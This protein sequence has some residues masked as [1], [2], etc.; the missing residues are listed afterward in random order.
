MGGTEPTSSAV[1]GG[2][3]VIPAWTYASYTSSSDRLEM[4]FMFI[5]KILASG[6]RSI[7]ERGDIRRDD[8][9]RF[10][11]YQRSSLVDSGA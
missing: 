2:G 1:T 4:A 5:A 6:I 11:Q 3:L 10:R 9:L 8:L 7:M